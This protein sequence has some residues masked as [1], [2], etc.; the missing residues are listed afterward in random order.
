MAARALEALVE[1]GPTRSGAPQRRCLVTRRV[2]DKDALIRFVLGPG[3]AVLA[4]VAG[5]LPGRGVW[6]SAERGVVEAACARNLF[7]K[8]FRVSVAVEADLADRVERLLARRCLDLLGLARRS[9]AAAAG[10]EKVHAMLAAGVCG[11]LVIAAEAGA[12]GR[13]R[14]GRV[15]PD[16]PV[17]TLFSSS[18]LAAALGRE[19]VVYA[20]VKEGRMAARLTAESGRLAGFRASAEASRTA[21]Q[22]VTGSHKV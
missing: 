5:T 12:D 17:V 13:R 14:L 9:G 15:A 21:G 20:A 7:A 22:G 2:G 11:V 6:L 16:V 10:F 18:E 19:H 8:G 1:D 4:D 3:D